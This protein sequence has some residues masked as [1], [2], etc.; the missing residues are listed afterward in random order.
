MDLTTVAASVEGH[1]AL[2]LRQ[3][4]P[5]NC[6]SMRENRNNRW[7][8]WCE[9]KA[10]F[11][12][13]ADSAIWCTTVG[14]IA[15]FARGM[16]IRASFARWPLKSALNPCLKPT[17]AARRVGQALRVH[18]LP[19]FTRVTSDVL[20]LE[21]SGVSGFLSVAGSPA[22]RA[23]RHRVHLRTP[24]CYSESPPYVSH[25]HEH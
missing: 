25:S 6:L 18:E 24:L 17:R 1:A 23:S 14:I 22:D 12:A 4:T 9:E 2:E 3:W 19:S 21:A 13:A 11:I 5:N 8:S 15:T 20:G 16:T 10:R 7:R